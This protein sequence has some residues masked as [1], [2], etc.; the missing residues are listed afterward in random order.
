MIAGGRKE[1]DEMKCD[2]VYYMG[3][4]RKVYKT[5]LYCNLRI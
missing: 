2:N 3:D 5:Y 1:G 4:M